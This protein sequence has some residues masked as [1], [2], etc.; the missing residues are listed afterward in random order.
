MNEKP[1]SCSNLLIIG[2]MSRSG[3]SMLQ[4]ICNG[5]PE[6]VMTYESRIFLNTGRRFPGYYRGLNKKKKRATYKQ[7]AALSGYTRHAA[8]LRFMGPLLLQGYRKIDLAAVHRALQNLFPQAAYI[9]D[10]YP[11]YLYQ[12]SEFADYADM[13]IVI[14]YRD[15]RD[16]AQSVLQRMRTDWK[17]KSW[18]EKNLR[19]PQDIAIRWVESIERMEAY[20]DRVY[21]IRYETLVNNPEAEFARLAEYLGI[22]PGGFDYSDITNASVGKYTQELTTQQLAEFMEVA[23]PTL[24]RLGYLD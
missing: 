6:I 16:I 1:N 23:G 8:A 17:D 7:L 4:K 10:K 22:D 21:V 13:R 18:A 11:R 15:G 14:I 5:H 24:E 20:R 19:T 12:L 3:T 2:G 9:G